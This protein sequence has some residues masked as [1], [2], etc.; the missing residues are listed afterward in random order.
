MSL[1]RPSISFEFSN[2]KINVF[3]L[4]IFGF[5]GNNLKVP[6]CV[7]VGKCVLDGNGPIKEIMI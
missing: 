3:Y 7:K 5:K 4:V 1:R 2:L 6:H